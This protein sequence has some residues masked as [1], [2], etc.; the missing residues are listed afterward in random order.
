METFELCK[1]LHELKPDW[2]LIANYRYII[3][4]KARESRIYPEDVN[5]PC[6]DCAPEYTLEYLLDKLPDAIESKLGLGALTL[7]SR[8]MQHR[9]GWLVFY[10]DDEGCSVDASL[11]FAAE[12][13]LDAVLKLAIAM[14]E[15]RLV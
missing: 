6:Y 1:K 3:K 14:A 4:F 2:K 12:A 11:V 10:G 15:K 5:R 8:Q 9:D 7:S 13:P